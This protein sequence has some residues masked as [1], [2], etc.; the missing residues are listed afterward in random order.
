[1]CGAR[2][3][4]CGRDAAAKPAAVGLLAHAAVAPSDVAVV[5][6]GPAAFAAQHVAAA[7]VRAEPAAERVESAGALVRA[8]PAVLAAERVVAA[9]VVWA[10]AAAFAAQRVLAAAV[11][12]A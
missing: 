8:G 11:V 6:A 10:G 12:R 4:S 7:V 1:M 9:A 5:R 3:P 2:T